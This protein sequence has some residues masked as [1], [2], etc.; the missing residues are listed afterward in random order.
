[1][2]R[3]EV[4]QYPN[5]LLRRVADPVGTVTDAIRRLADDMLETMYDEPGIGLAA[6]QVNAPIRLIVVDTQWTEAEKERKPCVFL[7]P[8]LRSC[9][10]DIVWEEGCLSVPDLR[11]EVRRAERVSLRAL[12]LDGKPVME[13]VEGLRAVCLQH[14]ID[15]LD[16]VLFLDR[17]RGLRRDLYVRRRKKDYRA[18]GTAWPARGEHPPA[19]P[20]RRP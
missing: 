11:G 15:H 19:P 20:T 7:N 10:G 2:A 3:L 14:E 16:G 12:D 9:A 4:L 13:D 8:E 6:P 5:P 1:M 18:E 17:L